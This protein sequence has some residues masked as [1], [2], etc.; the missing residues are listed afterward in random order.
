[1]GGIYGIVVNASTNVQI[2]GGVCRYN[3]AGIYIADPGTGVVVVGADVSNSI[4]G[5]SL[6][7]AAT[8]A[9][10]IKGIVANDCTAPLSHPTLGYSP[11][12]GFVVIPDVPATTASLTNPY[13]FPCAVSIYGGTVTQIGLDARNVGLTSGTLIL[14]VGS[15]IAITYSSVPTW[16]WVSLT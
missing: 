11:L 10:V 13:P 1:M 12:H 14:A 4:Y 8:S 15:V 7:T 6:E 3:T 5:I 16:N 9:A 2:Q